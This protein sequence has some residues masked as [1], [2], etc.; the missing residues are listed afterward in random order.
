MSLFKK[1]TPR[2]LRSDEGSVLAEIA[3]SIPLYIGLLSGMFEVGNYAILHM[4]IQHTVVTIADLM[5]RDEEINES[6]MADIFQVVPEILAPYN[7]APNTI[8]IVSAISQTEDIPI[9]V[10]WQRSGGGTLTA[11]SELGLEGETAIL[12]NT[13]TLRDNE[14][15][16]AT[17]VFYHFEPLIF[18][19]LP[20]T[21]IRRVSYFR[22][23]IGALQEIES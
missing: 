6:V 20:E 5:T 1:L 14:T 17:E 9:S 23:R 13:L 7:A 8:T 3:L 2:L 10:F 11:T 16:L 18:S 19:F 22:P 4:K 12:P 15:I 21:T